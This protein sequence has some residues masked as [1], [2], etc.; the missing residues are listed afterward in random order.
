MTQRPTLASNPRYADFWESARLSWFRYAGGTRSSEFW[1]LSLRRHSHS[2]MSAFI[3][4][5]A[6]RRL[7][8]LPMRGNLTPPIRR[9]LPRQWMPR[10]VSSPCSWMHRAYCRPQSIDQSAAKTPQHYWI[11]IGA[12]A[13]LLVASGVVWRT[14]HEP[15]AENSATSAVA[16]AGAVSG[17]T[18]R[19]VE[20]K[21]LP[22]KPS[23]SVTNH[24]PDR[25][26]GKVL[27]QNAAKVEATEDSG[28]V[29]SVTNS[30]YAGDHQRW[31]TT[32][33]FGPVDPSPL[34]LRG[35]PAPSR[36]ANGGARICEQDSDANRCRSGRLRRTAP[37]AR[38]G[39]KG[40][41]GVVEAKV[42][43]KVDP[44]HPRDALGE[45]ILAQ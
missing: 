30:P 40:F 10:R 16:R 2:A 4:W 28:T 6:S 18:S 14:W 12:L 26:H 35:T 23:A 20:S 11:L 42:I 44:V 7:P 19:A 24:P 25:S 13:M 39:P 33:S 21:A 3:F 41:Q 17:E 36:S 5:K 9:S 31:P 1:K 22:S 15:A 32:A 43:S 34:I 37:V 29:R 8:R 38:A 45:K 27:L